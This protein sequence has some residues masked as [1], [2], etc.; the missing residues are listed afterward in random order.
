MASSLAHG[1]AFP[2][3]L[4]P[5]K[6]TVKDAFQVQTAVHNFS[7]LLICATWN[8]MCFSPILLALTTKLNMMAFFRLLSLRCANFVGCKV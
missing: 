4:T 2:V 8:M 1:A 7:H 6:N 3:I 5:T